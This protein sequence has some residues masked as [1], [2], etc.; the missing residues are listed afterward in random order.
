MHFS[1]INPVLLSN[2]LI[3]GFFPTKYDYTFLIWPYGQAS[4]ERC[5]YPFLQI[6]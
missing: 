3:V 2:L 6:V 1:I 4:V 5:S